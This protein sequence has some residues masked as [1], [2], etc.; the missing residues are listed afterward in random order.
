[1]VTTGCLNIGYNKAARVDLTL[2]LAILL[3]MFSS[4]TTAEDEFF[5][6]NTL[7]HGDNR[8]HTNIG[9]LSNDQLRDRARE[10]RSQELNA[11]Q[12]ALNYQWLES[13]HK[14][15]F[16]S[17]S[18]AYKTFF[19]KGFEK[20]WDRQRKERFKSNK[21][22][23]IHGKGRVSNEVDYDIKLSSDELK[24]GLSYEF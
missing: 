24:I 9:H 10:L 22:P 18:K 4:I 19:K 3:S 23:D 1:M 14:N 12:R 21:V 5:L 8:H 13:H 2:A 11:Y 6:P 7:I 16:L 15:E 20:Y 17:G